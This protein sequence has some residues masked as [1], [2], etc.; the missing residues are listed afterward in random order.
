[1]TL[2]HIIPKSFGGRLT[3]RFLCQ[4][5]NATLGHRLE[6]AARFDPS[7]RIAVQRLAPTIPDI[8]GQLAENQR[9]IG[10]SEAGLSP[11]YMR[12]GDFRVFS[13]KL[14]DGS[15]V[16]PTNEAKKSVERILRKE[17]YEIPPVQ[18]ALRKFDEAP[19]N[20]KIEIA[21]GLQIVKWRIEKIQPDFS[22]RPL[23]SPL[24][25]FK[26]AYE[27]I[28]CH[29]GAA[30]YENV[31]PLIDIRQAFQS[32]DTDSGPFRIERLHAAEY[33]PFHGICFEGNNPHASIQIRMFGWLAFRVHFL[34][35]AVSGSRFIYT[36]YLDS[37]AEDIRVLDNASKA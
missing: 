16:Q 7:I 15:L 17:G 1:M 35:L 14:P 6:H 8:A 30:V 20:M 32:L 31:P 28:A 29:L 33:K 19:E 9:H 24:V 27:F 18:E 21:P 2:E 22:E 26:I 10:Q 37:G 3:S 23:M 12:E 34:R 25:P 11:G 13:R 4:P 36:H 5:C